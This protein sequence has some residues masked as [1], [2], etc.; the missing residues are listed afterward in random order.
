M[1]K[2][3][4][5]ETSSSSDFSLFLLVRLLGKFQFGG[6]YFFSV[7]KCRIDRGV[8]LE[9][10]VLGRWLQE[11]GFVLNSP[12]QGIQSASGREGIVV[13]VT[14]SCNNRNSRLLPL[15]DSENAEN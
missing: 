11:E 10:F 1:C 9:E 12:I 7:V 3:S 2:I 13:E 15:S 5:W 4:S 6:L 14:H 8:A